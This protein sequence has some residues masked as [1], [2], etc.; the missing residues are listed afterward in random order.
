MRERQPDPPPRE[1]RQP[2]DPIVE[3][4]DSD[5]QPPSDRE[6]DVPDIYFRT[7]YDEDR[8][9][10]LG[11]VYDYYEYDCT[12]VVSSDPPG[13]DV[14]LDNLYL[15]QTP[16]TRTGMQAGAA[17]LRLELEGYRT[18]ERYISLRRKQTNR[19]SFTLEP[20]PGTFAS[21]D[22]NSD[23]QGA[24]LLVNGEVRGT[25]PYAELLVPPGLVHLE[26]RKKGH[27]TV[28][29]DIE[30]EEG[31]HK[32]VEVYLPLANVPTS[33]ATIHVTS[34]PPDAEIYLNGTRL[35][36]TPLTHEGIQPGK[37]VIFARKEG[38]ANAR[39]SLPLG[40][41][42]DRDISFTLNPL[43]GNLHVQTDPIGA[44]VYVDG[45]K[46]GQAGNGGVTRNDIAIGAH[47]VRAV[48][49]G[50]LDAEELVMVSAGETSRVSLTLPS[51]DDIPYD[52]ADYGQLSVETFPSGVE[53]FL[54]YAPTGKL[55]PALFTGLTP[56]R[57]LVSVSLDGYGWDEQYVMVRANTRARVNLTLD[58]R[59]YTATR[60][61]HPRHTPLNP[62]GPYG[63]YGVYGA[64]DP[65]YPRG[66][67]GSNDP[68]NEVDRYLVD[69]DHSYDEGGAEEIA[70]V[71]VLKDGSLLMAGYRDEAG[72]R[73]GLLMKVDPFGEKEWS[74]TYDAR[75][76]D[77]FTSIAATEDFGFIV[78]G[79]TS[80]D[81][82]N[83]ADG[84]LLLCDNDGTEIWS[85]TY[86]GSRWD[87]A[88][89][90]IQAEDKGFYFAGETWS[91][92]LGFSDGWLVKTAPD[93]F[94]Q[95]SRRYGGRGEDRFTD[96]AL[97]SK[98]DIYLVGSRR[99]PLTER[100]DGWL[101]R[102]APTGRE[103]SSRTF[104]GN[105]DD[106]FSSLALTQDG[107]LVMAGYTDSEGM[108][109]RN[110][111]MV[112]LNGKGIESWSR[113]FGGYDA[114]IARDIKVQ[115]YGYI[116]CGT[117]K[118]MDE[119]FDP[120]EHA[121][122]I[123]TDFRGEATWYRDFS[124]TGATSLHAIGVLNRGE[125]AIVGDLQRVNQPSDAWAMMLTPEEPPP[126]EDDVL[127]TP[128]GLMLRL[129]DYLIFR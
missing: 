38:Y 88:S 98:G 118:P 78:A 69:W 28:E 72:A 48:K 57:Y 30:V 16:L 43:V 7:G 86:G 90:V 4:P 50:Y 97:D 22:V 62:V 68:W 109:E 46:L 34:D 129:V 95:W 107:G 79:V 10:P 21:L 25:T 96:I 100:S 1:P 74:L 24:T 116:L 123:R 35:G 37:A 47:I 32:A 122:V 58:M 125:F 40:S 66:R 12:L 26:L 39:Q 52:P 13:A 76:F 18:I 113:T 17:M 103:R 53:I 9:R 105:F 60:W 117:T 127:V 73:D 5:Y 108:L 3:D 121:W 27:L 49:H 85:R 51:T 82:A 94:V 120:K 65:S 41:G 80:P 23:P 111:W 126:S 128:T 31:Q 14:F 54:N 84:W 114:G 56:G 102:A 19:V 101:V 42:E 77:A 2:R 61:Q 11:D 106:G 63:G 93:G 36:R 33:P 20:L 44:V 110:A 124:D 92:G 104:G 70:D 91:E 87:G 115:R 89:A 83:E 55:S 119:T 71:L 29:R 59:P 6:N 8:R 67:V 15:G 99:D 75:G 64:Y 112:R 45:V 81:S